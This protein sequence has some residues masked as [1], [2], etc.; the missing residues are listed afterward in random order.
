MSRSYH[1]TRRN[2]SARSAAGDT[3][4]M[5][6]LSEKEIVKKQARKDGHE[7]R[8]SFLVGLVRRIRKPNR[9]RR[10]IL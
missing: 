7:I 5:E 9:D 3:V 6:E 8:N 1:V 2:A 4:A 10:E